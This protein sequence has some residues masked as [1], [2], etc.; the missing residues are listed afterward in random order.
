MFLRSLLLQLREVIIGF[1]R[2]CSLTAFN[3]NVCC[4]AYH[5]NN[6]FLSFYR[7]RS[8]PCLAPWL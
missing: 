7:L 8:V 1:R 4:F 6:E 2:E 5:T 3:V